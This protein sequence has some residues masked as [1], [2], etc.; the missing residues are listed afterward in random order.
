[1]A[2]ENRIDTDWEVLTSPLKSSVI[3][4]TSIPKPKDEGILTVQVIEARSLEAGTSTTDMIGLI[5]V[6]TF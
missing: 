4:Q 5:Q 1:M 6:T 2:E 3:F